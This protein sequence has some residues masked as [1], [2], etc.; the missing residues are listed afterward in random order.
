VAIGDLDRDG[1]PDVVMRGETG[2]VVTL[3]KQN[4]PGSWLRRDLVPGGE[5]KGWRWPTSTRTGFSTL[6]WGDDG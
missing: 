2:S 6:S 4:G 1:K 3:F 5:R